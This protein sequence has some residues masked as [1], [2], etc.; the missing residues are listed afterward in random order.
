[1]PTIS[2]RSLLAIC[3]NTDAEQNNLLI[4]HDDE[5]KKIGKKNMADTF[6]AIFMLFIQHGQ[7]DENKQNEFVFSVSE[8]LTH[9]VNIDG[10]GYPEH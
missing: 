7:T 2:S 3:S 10:L 1:M 4:N 9:G 8:P 5:N 6:F